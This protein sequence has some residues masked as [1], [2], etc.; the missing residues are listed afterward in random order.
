MT[1]AEEFFRELGTRGHE[2]LLSGVTGVVRFD[3]V[4]GRVA[5]PPPGPERVIQPS[6]PIGPDGPRWWSVLATAMR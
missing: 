2:P 5:N 4:D 3:V 6:M 1:A